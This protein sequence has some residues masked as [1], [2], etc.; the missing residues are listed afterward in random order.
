MV[1]SCLNAVQEPRLVS[2]QLATSTCV[3]R[4]EMVAL[5]C[6][7]SCYADRMDKARWTQVR[8]IFTHLRDEGP[9]FRA[10][11]L[12]MVCAD[13]DDLRSEVAAMLAAH[14]DMPQISVADHAVPDWIGEYKL[15]EQLGSGGMGAVYSA[16]H[17]RLGEVAIKVLSTQFAFLPIA[18]KRL[19]QEAAVL[20]AIEHPVLCTFH[21]VLVHEG[22]TAI[23]MEKV[24]GD[25]L[26]RV[27]A[28][29][30]LA[31]AR[32]LAIAIDLADV[33]SIAHANGIVH[34]DIKPSNVMFTSGGETRLIDF[35]IARLSDTRLTST[36][37][38]LGSPG[39]MSPE[40]WRGE[41]V[42]AKTDIWSLGVLLHHMCCGQPPFAG[43]TITEIANSVLHEPPQPL[44]NHDLNGEP[45]AA[46]NALVRKM[47]EKQRDLRIAS[48][49]AVHAELQTL[50][51]D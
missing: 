39:H 22:L 40:Q 20:E 11:Y 41:A 29:G 33:L 46:L 45:L 36:G 30:S 42:D 3:R 49:T 5:R 32:A 35:G 17:A 26:G 1:A 8:D 24:A 25:D 47:L 28:G 21:E 2:L 27:L 51:G 12:D 38:V 37:Q 16:H 7:A 15:G 14:D 18:H 10:D 9:S 4:I 31:L 13:D 44:P 23:V 50:A 6:F 34:R 48:M 19:E 43:D